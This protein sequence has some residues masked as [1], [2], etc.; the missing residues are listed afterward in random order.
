MSRFRDYVIALKLKNKPP[1]GMFISTGDNY[2]SFR[3]Q[4]IEGGETLIIDGEGHEVD[5]KEIEDP[6]HYLNLQNWAKDNFDVKEFLYYWSTYDWGTKDKIPMAG[7]FK[8]NIYL[9][10]DF[11]GW[12]MSNGTVCSKLISDLILKKDNPFVKLYKM[13]K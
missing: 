4:V 13:A 12:G 10:T 1:E 5:D 6:I 3:T 7:Y 2:H 11:G 9:A 8:D